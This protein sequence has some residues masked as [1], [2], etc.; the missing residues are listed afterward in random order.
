VS[1]VKTCFL[2]CGG[3]LSLLQSAPLLRLNAL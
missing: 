3:R 2:G 1:L